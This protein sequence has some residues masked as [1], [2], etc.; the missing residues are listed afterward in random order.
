MRKFY[1]AIVLMA[2]LYLNHIPQTRAQ[3][4]FDEIMMPKGEICFA[5]I[6]ENGKWNQYWE[7]DY[8]RENAN[9]GT[10]TRQM[11]MPMVAMG[12][13]KKINI[14][15]SLPYISTE[16]SG[17]TQVGQSGIQDLNVSMKVDWLQHRVGSG[18]ILFLT[19]T[20]FST[21]VGT[22]LSDYMPFSIGAG[23]PEVGVRG[24]GGYKMDNGLVFRMAAA[25]L[26]RGQTEI[27]RDYYYK[28][29]SVY[30]TFMNVPNALNIH[31]AIG[32]CTLENRLRLEATYMSLN[33]LSGDDIRAYN[34]PQPTNKMEVSQIGFWTQYY[35]KADRGFGA[36]AYLNHTITGRNM[37]KATAIGLGLTYQFKAY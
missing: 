25:Y 4:P 2:I 27:E 18:R 10:L 11:F 13:T 5:G 3:M 22:Y 19:N 29:G 34:R 14:I 7:G 30:S 21:P 33:C 15:A 32:Y 12:L 28:N 17:G 8:L 36:I 37:G 20:H 26:W 9:I 6:Y 16:A 24:I 31:G 1:C 23:A 35:I